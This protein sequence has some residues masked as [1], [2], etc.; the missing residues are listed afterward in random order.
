METHETKMND[1]PEK[2]NAKNNYLN[3]ITNHTMFDR[4]DDKKNFMDLIEAVRD[5]S[6]IITDIKNLVRSNGYIYALCL[7]LCEDFHDNPENLHK[8][9]NY[10]RLNMN[11]LSLLLGFLVQNHINFEIPSSLEK[12][13]EIK[14]RTYELLREL[15]QSFSKTLPQKVEEKIKNPEMKKMDFFG[16]DIMVESIFYASTGAYDFQYIDF[17]KKK[18][19][20]D[21]K[22]LATN[23]KF[24][25]DEVTV[26]YKELKKML[27]EKFKKVNLYLKSKIPEIK[28]NAKAK[29]DGN[30]F[31]KD[32]LKFIQMI[33][34]HQY[35]DLF[36]DESVLKF[37]PGTDEH[38][39]ASRKTFCKNL[40][41]LFVV[42]K[43]DLQKYSGGEAFIKNFSITAGPNVNS[44]FKDINSY[45]ITKS[46]PLIEFDDDR[47]LLPVS[48]ILA[49]A[50][51][52]S[53][54]YWMMK[55]RNY[56]EEYRKHRGNA[57]EDIVFE[58]LSKV[59]KKNTYRRILVKSN[60][61][62]TDTDID[63]LC[64][65]GNKALC[66][67]VKSQKL[68]E[69][70]RKGD[71]EAL[72]S[73]FKKAVQAAYEQAWVARE[74]ILDRSSKFFDEN[75][76][77]IKL[78]E[79]INEVYMAI[80]TTENYP[81]LTPQ[82][83]FLMLN[84]HEN[85]PSPLAMTI[86]DLELVTH[87]LTDP[88][89][90]LYYIRQRI[91]LINYFHGTEEIVFLSYHLT[92]KLWKDPK[93]LLHPLDQNL[94]Q[95][96]HRNYI[97]LREGVN[98]SDKGDVI[99]SR[100]KDDKFDKLCTQIKK[101]S[102]EKTTDIVFHLYDLS[103]NARSGLVKNMEMVKNKTKKD[104]RFH[105]FSIPPDNNYT[106]RFGISYF[107]SE[108]N[109]LE[110]VGR[111]LLTLC[112]IGKY[113]SRGDFWLGF[114]SIKDSPNMIDFLIY[115][116]Q[117]WEYDEILEKEIKRIPKKPMVH[118][119]SLKEIGRNEKC[120]CGSGKKFKNCCLN[121]Y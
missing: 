80:I 81:S 59:F 55:D 56:S 58:Y 3:E 14:K 21:K 39:D 66:V 12:L 116:Y 42:K 46:H 111:R 74:K 10:D 73:D 107:S 67:Q 101:I 8:E 11:E 75:G 16:K 17:L 50:I 27:S 113:R 7:I 91:S 119:G 77:A 4:S 115:D 117:P 108:T 2:K 102:S 97:P 5:R 99:K 15:H 109:S 85:S 44:S 25:F 65:L 90:F 33:E 30:N 83:H 71:D 89:D 88:Y 22:W 112:K 40:L 45:N 62:R 94:S 92:N 61:G 95:I 79:I 70:S 60:K 20:Y 106:P 98:V 29:Y 76:S 93:Y 78:P 103:G 63:V 82:A 41:N 36:I 31:E 84:L 37:T 120:P 13:S 69:I 19:R 64:V 104:G 48:F 26:I 114:G 34:F 121:K 105:D 47:M 87:Y 68:R 86:F 1:K 57:G 9:N 28:E 32:F 72:K 49:E 38:R 6:E 18:Y 35:S 23:K 51:Y 53:P 96:I 54:F 52:E 24:K 43:S 118:A 110:E 100:W